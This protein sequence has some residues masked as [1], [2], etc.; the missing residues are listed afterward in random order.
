MGCYYVPEGQE[1]K[2]IAGSRRKWVEQ[3][4][5]KAERWKTEKI[6]TKHG[7]PMK[8][9]GH[10]WAPVYCEQCEYRAQMIVGQES[11]IGVTHSCP[12]NTEKVTKKMERA[13]Q[14]MEEYNRNPP[15]DGPGE[16][17]QWK[18]KH[19]TGYCKACG[20]MIWNTPQKNDGLSGRTCTPTGITT[21]VKCDGCPPLGQRKLAE[22][23]AWAATGTT[24]EQREPMLM[25]K[26]MRELQ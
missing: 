7:A 20:P 15:K 21:G 18:F 25:G 17:H 26:K 1:A 22:V 19:N 24:A 9:A 2:R 14:W 8:W 5:A 10:M 6:E 12:G 16:P 11:T 4:R 23:M 3:G 13:K